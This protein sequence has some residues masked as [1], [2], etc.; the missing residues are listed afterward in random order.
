MKKRWITLLL[1]AVCAVG[2]VGCGNTQ[3]G[4][5]YPDV[6]NTPGDADSWT[7]VDEEFTIDWYVDYPWFTYETT[8]NDDIGKKVKEKT[9]V[10]VR[11]TSPVQ[12]DSTMLNL[13]IQ[14]DEM[15]DVISVKAYQSQQAQLALEGYVFPIDELARRWAPSLTDRIEQD[16]YDYYSIGGHLYGLPNCAY[17]D[18]Y[19]DA[20]TKWE[21]NGAMLVRKDWYEW[22]VAQPGAKD[23]TT[24]AGL[25]DALQ[26]VKAQFATKSQKVIPML[27]DEF[28]GEGCQS[29]TWLSQYFAAPFEDENGG[30]LDTRFTEQYFEA[31]EYLNELNQAELLSSLSNQTEVIG[32]IISRGEAFVTLVTP[33]NYA[34]NFIAAYRG[35]NKIEY[36]PLILRNDAGDDPVLQDMTGRG[37]LLSMITKS[38]KR[39]D[40]VIKV[41]DFLYSEEGQRLTNFGIEN[42]TWKWQDEQK[43]EI[44]WTQKYLTAKASESGALDNYGLEKLNVL[45]NPAYVEPLKPI[46]ALKDYELYAKNLK[47]PL[48]PYSYRYTVSWP[49]LDKT[50]KDYKSIVKKEIN[51]LAV[52][53]EYLPNMIKDDARAQYDTAVSQMQRR[54]L[55]DVLAFYAQAYAE[56]KRT[57]G[58]DKGWIPATDGYVAPT[59][60]NAD[61]T[62]S[63]RPIGANG[64]AYYILKK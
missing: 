26:K 31:V 12:N 18:K 7:Y 17:S 28:T 4:L 34:S 8:A 46:S 32:G 64:D 39:P 33:Q 54:G 9:G 41:F 13:L 42:D 38:C 25:K 1:A 14:N 45:Y 19:V 49:K 24:K 16:L 3:S 62:A 60:K 52:W 40:L 36:I 53:S 20:D 22:Y 23:I 59:L 15:P 57:T 61:G 29:V 11:F 43:T 27:L 63:D 6:P 37:W 50:A 47:R 5:V 35:S 51:C 48:M 55:D 2:A 58:V 10:T 30:Y 44:E 21:P 56:T